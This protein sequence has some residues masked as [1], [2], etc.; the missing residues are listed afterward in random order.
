MIKPVSKC[1]CALLLVVLLFVFVGCDF[2]A[3]T[4][5]DDLP[6]E[7]ITAYSD[8][9]VLDGDTFKVVFQNT[10]CYKNG[11]NYLLKIDLKI[12]NKKYEAQE[13]TVKNIKT[14]KESTGSE[15][16]NQQFIARKFDIEAELSESIEVL[17]T[18]PTSVSTDNYKLILEVNNYEITYCLY[19]TPDNLR[20]DRNISYYINGELVKTDS[21]KDGKRISSIFVYESIDNMLYCNT[22]YKDEERKYKFD[23]STQITANTSLYGYLVSIFEWSTTTSDT[24]SFLSGVNHVP[25]NGILVIPEKNQHKELCINMYAIR[26]IK[27]TA[28]YVPKTV[29]T[30]YSGNFTG[31]GNAT[32][33]YAGTEEEWEALFYNKSEIPTENVV[34]NTPYSG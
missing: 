16:L 14:I 32:I 28:I 2:I 7:S 8:N 18:I 33:F 1:F 29:H 26:N 4:I 30:I 5:N 3:E 12:V 6:K 10:W 11:D 15:Y 9:K 24:Y 17:F 13:I 34:F 25:S 23:F 19:A 20:A 21:V 31:I 22:W 27:L